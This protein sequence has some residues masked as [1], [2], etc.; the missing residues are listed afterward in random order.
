MSVRLVDVSTGNSGSYTGRVY[1]D[2]MSIYYQAVST[3]K[4]SANKPTIIPTLEHSINLIKYVRGEAIPIENA[5]YGNGKSSVGE[6]TDRPFGKKNPSNRNYL[7]STG[8]FSAYAGFFNA[9]SGQTVPVRVFKKESRI[10]SNR[11]RIDSVEGARAYVE[12]AVSTA[13]DNFRQELNISNLR[14]QATNHLKDGANKD[15]EYPYSLDDNV[16]ALQREYY[17]MLMTGVVSSRITHTDGTPFDA[18]LSVNE[19]INQHVDEVID[20]MFGEFGDATSFNPAN[21]AIYMSSDSNTYQNNEDLVKALRVL[22]FPPENI[23]GTDNNFYNSTFIDKLVKFDKNTAVPMK[24]GSPFMRDIFAALKETISTTGCEVKDEDILIDANG[25]VQYTVKQH[26]RRSSMP[27]ALAQRVGQ[28]GQIFEPDGY[29]VVRTKFFGRGSDNYLTVP[30]Y[31]AYVLPQKEGENLTLEERT[32]LV[33]YKQRIIQAAQHQVRRDLMDVSQIDTGGSMIAGTPTSINN[34]IYNSLYEE[35]FSLDFLDRMNE[36]VEMKQLTQAVIETL[37]GKY[38]YSNDYRE[39]STINA[40]ARYNRDGVIKRDMMGARRDAYLKTDSNISV[41]EENAGRYVDRFATSTSTSQGQVRYLTKS[42]K[43]ATD[44]HIIPGNDGDHCPLLDLDMCKYMQY[45]AAD[46]VAMTFNNLIS[47][48]RVGK[49]NVASMSFG[50][51]TFDDGYV[52][53]KSYAERMGVKSKSGEIRPLT[54]G[55]KISDLH[56]N[57]GVI[58]YVI[59]PDMPDEEADAKGLLQAV[60]WFRAN[61]TL[62]AVGAPYAGVSRFNGGSA[63]EAMSDTF[64]LTTPDGEVIKG[65][66]GTMTFLI[67]NMVVDDKTHIYGLDSQMKG[68]G[69]KVSGQAAWGLQSKQAYAIA[70]ELYG[71]NARALEIAR[72]H[73]AVLGLDI[74][75]YGEI[76]PQFTEQQGIAEGDGENRTV[77]YMPTNAEI[78]SIIDPTASAKQF[79]QTEHFMRT[80]GRQG[81]IMEL[82]FPLKL[83]TGENTLTL[84][85]IKHGENIRRGHNTSYGLPVMSAS[86]RTGQEFEDGGGSSVHDYTRRYMQIYNRCVDYKVLESYLA[87]GRKTGDFGKPRVE[88]L[89]KKDVVSEK[90]ILDAMKSCQRKAQTEYDS[91][92]SDVSAKFEGKKSIFRDGLMARSL[93]NSAT[94]VW[95]A[96]P[97]LK[98]DEVAMSSAMAKD[99]GFDV[100][101]VRKGED[102]RVLM[103]RDPLLRDSGIKYMNVVIDDSLTGI[104]VNPVIDKPFDGDFDGDTIGM[105]ALQSKEAKKEAYE[106]FSIPATMLDLSSFDEEKGE[107]KLSYHVDG[108][109]LSCAMANFPELKKRQDELQTTANKV[110]RANVPAERKLDAYQRLVNAQSQLTKEAFEKSCGGHVLVYDNIDK[111]F[112]SYETFVNDG[113]KGSISKLQDLAKY[114]GAELTLDESGEHIVHVDDKKTTLS[115]DHDRS[116]TQY[117]TAVKAFATGIA[118][119]FSQRGVKALRHEDIQAVL[120]VTYLVTQSVLQI[121][122]NPQQAKQTYNIM[123]GV[124]RDLWRGNLIEKQNGQWQ[125]VRTKTPTGWEPVKATPE[126]FKKT[127][128]DLYTGKD[129]L[130]VP[131]NKEFVDR[132]VKCLTTDDGKG[133]M[134]IED[135][136]V[137][138]YGDVLDKLTYNSGSQVGASVATQAYDIARKA[139]DRDSVALF[140]DDSVMACNVVRK[141]RAV[142]DGF[143]SGKIA[144]EDAHI[145]TIG[146]RDTIEGSIDRVS[147]KSGKQDVQDVSARPQTQKVEVSV[148]TSSEAETKRKVIPSNFSEIA[149]KDMNKHISDSEIKSG[150]GDLGED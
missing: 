1:E 9:T 14:R 46:R 6:F 19:V 48:L 128:I 73:F 7:V 21:T 115:T 130:D 61:P 150:S 64:D 146:K 88:G 112:D 90:D 148:Q 95:S 69:R 119:S 134:S 41:I 33:G 133:I 65:G 39:N 11:L 80:V 121:K 110:Y 96:D 22:D 147:V 131:V 67:S 63:R 66:G 50:G 137:E 94:A 103:W 114:F 40:E 99:L 17:E 82:P 32:R 13:R 75:E 53:S 125:T 26:N 105:V 5:G 123:S 77:F 57:K 78:E 36:S 120:E 108:L 100:D 3:G 89:N 24:D 35:R 18:G 136:A 143:E 111:L 31:Q 83:Y 118:G 145:R 74:N 86:L 109:D 97:R 107:Y 45:N 93:P 44:G 47:A 76:K 4:G 87:Q 71:P 84:D 70:R 102:A 141:N 49:T 117:A 30:G 52:V 20:D 135:A 54:R 106:K 101:A 59:D 8:N 142:R 15:Y 132:I 124:L 2:G 34:K 116:D 79:N 91:I 43:V 29:G 122:H 28:I 12:N 58:S 81:G 37:A 10:A 98:I 25:V 144:K 62:D 139:T 56:G 55:D 149:E 51:F 23:K 104:S 127:F 16:A 85:D 92:A 129:G 42:A 72:E 140:P 38:R 68:K 113:A 126:Q 138:K 60:K 27:G